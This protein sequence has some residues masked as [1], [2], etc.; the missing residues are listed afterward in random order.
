MTPDQYVKSLERVLAPHFA[1]RQ[2]YYGERGARRLAREVGYGLGGFTV[3]Q[4]EEIKQSLY[5]RLLVRFTF[6][7]VPL[8]HRDWLDELNKGITKG[9]K[10]G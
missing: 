7:H 2:I 6:G 1:P 10:D 5:S 4:V 9:K 8:D 3:N